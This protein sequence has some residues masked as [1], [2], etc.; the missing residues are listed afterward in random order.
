MKKPSEGIRSPLKV[1]L[2]NPWVA[3]FHGHLNKVKVTPRVYRVTQC[4]KI[5]RR[6]DLLGGDV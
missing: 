4:M 1:P 2:S 3:L 5:E 6:I